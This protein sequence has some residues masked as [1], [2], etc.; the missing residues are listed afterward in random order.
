MSADHPSNPPRPS[1]PY[2]HFPL[3][4]HGAARPAKKIRGRMVYFGPWDDP[5]AALKKYLE[6]RDTL[7]AGRKPW[8]EPEGLSVKAPADA[9]LSHKQALPD[10][11]E[12]S[13]HTW[14]N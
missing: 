2:P 13:P 6:E 3:L 11:G 1:K 12:L 10:A 9:L 5:D 8:T 4:P 7:H 14:L